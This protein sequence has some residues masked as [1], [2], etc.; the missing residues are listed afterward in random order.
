MKQTGLLDI[1]GWQTQSLKGFK[2]RKRV[3]IAT[4][5]RIVCLMLMAVIFL[6]ASRQATAATVIETLTG[7]LSG[8]TDVSG[9]FVGKGANLSGLPFKLVYTLDTVGGVSY[10]Q[11][12]SSCDNGRINSGLKTPIPKAVLTINGKSYTFGALPPGSIYSWVTAGTATSPRTTSNIYMGA[13]FPYTLGSMYGYDYCSAEISLDSIPID[14]SCRYWSDELNYNLKAPLDV[15]EGEWTIEHSTLQNPQ[16]QEALGYFIVD[17]INVS[18]PIE[19]PSTPH[20]F[21][22]DATTGKYIDVTSAS[23]SVAVAVAASATPTAPVIAGTNPSV[24]VGQPIQVV[25]I[26]SETPVQP[27]AWDPEGTIV[28]GFRQD[29][30]CAN[31]LPPPN[32]P[33]GGPTQ[34][35]LTSSSTSFYWVT[36]S[37]GIETVTYSYTLANG[38]RRS[39]Q[40]KFDVTAPTTPVVA[41]DPIRTARILWL[42]PSV[43]LAPAEQLYMS[44]DIEF[45][46]TPP[47]EL[48][49]WIQI[50]Q[51]SHTSITALDEGKSTTCV[52]S[53]TPGLDLGSG[54]PNF[55]GAKANDT[56]GVPLE[57]GYLTASST[58]AAQ[59]YLMWKPNL[60]NSIPVPLGFT[61]W[62]FSESAN[63][64]PTKGVFPTYP[65]LGGWS[66]TPKLTWQPGSG[67]FNYSD[68]FPT[69]NSQFKELPRECK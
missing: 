50:G 67:T 33:C 47:S 68:Q 28:G 46:A 57:P 34:A 27:K 21:Y 48:Y 41:I 5:A 29:F 4:D 9:M 66:M 42:P 26:P 64:Q 38:Q 55:T 32:P 65:N 45:S 15:G 44:A 58:F 20:I 18:G 53:S 43:T 59:M 54:Y 13:N 25:A 36:P 14:Q 56:P 62:G 35:D 37:S 10:Y 69:W 61:S 49:E 2:V 31:P 17:S 6:Y 60:P 63:F 16:L 3:A 19:P 11:N 39:V 8:A 24:V 30:A 22:L 12:P 52:I 7:T 23:Q 51:M 40:A 1:I